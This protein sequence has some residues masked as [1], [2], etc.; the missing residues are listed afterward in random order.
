MYDYQRDLEEKIEY[1]THFLKV[2]AV[3]THQGRY[4]D[5]NPVSDMLIAALVKDQVESYEPVIELTES[6]CVYLPATKLDTLKQWLPY[7]LQWGWLKPKLKLV[8]EVVKHDITIN[9]NNYK[10]YVTDNSKRYVHSM[11][12]NPVKLSEYWRLKN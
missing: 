10:L 2:Y 3:N 9:I 8:M 6:N 12:R 1:E 7:D 5:Q 11:V 4:P